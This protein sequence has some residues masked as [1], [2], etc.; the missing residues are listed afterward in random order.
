MASPLV[1]L[2]VPPGTKKPL[3]S[4]IAP[5]FNEERVIG[6]FL[7]RV[8]AAL[9]PLAGRYDFEIILVDDGSRDRSL[10][11]MKA[12]ALRQPRLRVL[13]LRRNYGQTSALQAGLDAARGDVFITMDSDL[14]HFPEEIPQFLA[15][16]D[17]GFDLVCGWRHK[18]REG[19]IRRWPSRVANHCIRKLSGVSIHD[20]GTTF[21]AY[22][23]DLARDLRLFGEFHRYVPVLAHLVGG[24]ITELPIENIPR[25]EGK[26]NYGLGRTFGVFLDLLLLYFFVHYMDRPMR[27]FGKIALA[28]FVAG[29]SILVGLVVY[30]Y[31]ANFAT[32]RE[33]SGWFLLSIMLIL[34]S[35]HTLIGGILAEI[36]IRVHYAQGDRRVYQLRR[37][38]TSENADAKR[39]AG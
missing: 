8:V 24:R 36:L 26:S 20:F 38:W 25:P 12:Y 29:A 14:Q 18:R 39:C 6:Q 21:R 22:R 30:A 27:A 19:I 11:V 33:H 1:N 37:E 9:A 34:A 3:V 35:I 28:S 17:E 16:L 2:V 13:E 31:A 23:A 32:V 7:D 4:V 10:E 15:R 5:V